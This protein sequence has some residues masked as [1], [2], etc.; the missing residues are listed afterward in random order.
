MRQTYFSHQIVEFIPERIEDGILYVSQQYRTAVHKCAC[1]CGEEVVTPLGPTDWSIQ[2]TGDT[3]TLHPSIG[4][5]SFGCRS[6]Y[7]LRRGRVVWA[8]TLS[9]RQI[10]L[11]RALDRKAR[12][13]HFEDLN[14]EKGRR[15]QSLLRRAWAA[16][17]S[18]GRA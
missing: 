17:K 9:Q 10:E 7:F 6:H 4:N 2:I 18:W 8:S 1:G 11:G 12:Q 14:R 5:W 15:D 13:Q 16:L 3:A